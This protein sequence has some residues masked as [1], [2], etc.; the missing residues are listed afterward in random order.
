MGALLGLYIESESYRVVLADAHQPPAEAVRQ[1][2]A[3][4]IVVDVD[5]RDGFSPAFIAEQ[6]RL[7]RSVIAFSPRLLTDELEERASQV[8]V[9]PLHMPIDIDNVRQL[10]AAAAR[11]ATAPSIARPGRT[12]GPDS[13]SNGPDARP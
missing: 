11:D 2:G 13:H 6:R 8:R 5:H 7:G 10:L 3:S 9:P 12:N 4:I 1:A